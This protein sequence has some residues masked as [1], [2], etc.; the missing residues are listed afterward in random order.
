MNTGQIQELAARLERVL[1][2]HAVHDNEVRQLQG[3][4][5]I[6]IGRA[7][8]GLAFSPMEWRDI[9]GG[10]CFTEGGLRKYRNLEEAFAEFRLEITDCN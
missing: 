5:S 4:L 8:S 10:R 9:P 7:K 6:L 3:E 2:T 1:E